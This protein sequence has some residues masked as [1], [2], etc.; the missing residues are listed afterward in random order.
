MK[1]ILSICF[2]LG[3]MALF[4][5]AKAQDDIAQMV[6]E[7]MTSYY[8]DLVNSTIRSSPPKMPSD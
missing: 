7:E 3:F 1:K 2:L 8:K 6:T 5:P 4:M